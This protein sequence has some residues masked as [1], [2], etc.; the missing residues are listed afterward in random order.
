MKRFLTSCFVLIGVFVLNTVCYSTDVISKTDPVKIE[1]SNSV[2]A[3]VIVLENFSPDNLSCETSYYSVFIVKN[4]G[5][6]VSKVFK[7]SSSKYMDILGISFSY[8]F[9]SQKADLSLYSRYVSKYPEYK[10]LLLEPCN[11]RV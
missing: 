9:M 8:K 6:I 7:K 1:V 4:S 2:I 3:D 10:E 5:K 11:Y